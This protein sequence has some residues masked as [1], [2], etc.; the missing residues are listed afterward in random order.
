MPSDGLLTQ[1][2][3]GVQTATWHSAGV[4]L[5]KVKILGDLFMRIL[6]SALQNASG[7]NSWT[8][9]AEL[10]LDAGASWSTLPGLPPIA[11]STTPQSGEATLEL[12]LNSPLISPFMANAPIV[13]ATGTL[14]GA[15]SGATITVGI[16]DIVPSIV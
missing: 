5:A 13:R 3:P 7:A 4:T 11:C 1:A 16:V 9:T 14:A 6:Y 10:S 15:G 2:A 8:F 12:P